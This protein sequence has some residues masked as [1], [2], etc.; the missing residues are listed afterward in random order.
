MMNWNIV[1]FFGA[2]RVGPLARANL[3]LNLVY[4]NLGLGLGLDLDLAQM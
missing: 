3:N 1:K 2:P 4:L